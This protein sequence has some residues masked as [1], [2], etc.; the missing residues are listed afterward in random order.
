M[1]SCARA[2]LLPLCA[3][4]IAVCGALTAAEPAAAQTINGQVVNPTQLDGRLVYSSL[5]AADGTWSLRQRFAEGSTA[6]LPVAPFAQAPDADWGTL[7]D[8]TPRLV[9]SRAG[10][11]FVYDPV[12]RTETAA[13]GTHDSGREELQPTL[14]NG[15][16]G[17]WRRDRNAATDGEYRLFSLGTD[18][19][20]RVVKRLSATQSVLGADLNG[21]GLAVTALTQRSDTREVSVQV[22]HYNQGFRTV[23]TA[24]SGMLSS[25]FLGEPSWR[26]DYVHWAFA[27]RLDA[28]RRQIGRAHITQRGTRISTATPSRPADARADILGV[29]A[30]NLDRASPFWINTYSPDEENEARQPDSSLYPVSV[31][32]VT[33]R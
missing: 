26:G 2:S 28:P 20:S 22:K 9:Y 12:A 19:P 27:R 14:W 11:L 32:S 5:D 16:L 33:F 25:V 13:A 4:A 15:T 8:G 24:S 21:R 10:R 17:F 3:S 6:P 29:A 23:L 7:R 31:R 18:R 30:D 1:R